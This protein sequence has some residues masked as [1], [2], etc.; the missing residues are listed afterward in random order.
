MGRQDIYS[1]SR[2]MLYIYYIKRSLTQAFSRKQENK[3]CTESID[4][5]THRL[6]D[7]VMHN[8]EREAPIV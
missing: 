3:I 7:D 2:T 1:L 4:I 6:Y 8:H 5:V